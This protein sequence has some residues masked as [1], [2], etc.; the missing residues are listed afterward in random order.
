MRPAAA[1]L[2]WLTNA[3]FAA[4]LAC[5]ACAP[6]DQAEQAP[7]PP[8]SQTVP[9]DGAV[10]V[11]ADGAFRDAHGRFVLLHGVNLVDKRP[12]YLPS[13][14]EFGP[15]DASL[16]RDLGFNIVRLGF[17]WA[18]LEPER[19]IIDATYVARLVELVDLLGD[20]GI[21]VLLDSHQDVM[22]ERWGGE[23]FP[24][25]A[26]DDGGIPIAT[27]LGDWS[28]NVAQPSLWHAWDAFWAN[29]HGLVDRYV[30]AWQSVVA[31]VADRP[32]VLGYDLLNEPWPGSDFLSEGVDHQRMQPVYERLAVAIREID[33]D[34]VV[35]WEPDLATHLGRGSRIGPLGDTNVAESFHVYCPLTLYGVFRVDG[36]HSPEL[37]GA[38]SSHRLDLAA[39]DRARVGGGWLMTEFGATAL[40]ADAALH[41]E[42]ADQHLVGWTWW[43][44]KRLDDPTGEPDEALVPHDTGPLS[45]RSTALALERI[46]PRTVAGTP[47]SLHSDP[48]APTG[49]TSFELH[50]TADPAVSA[51]T[52]IWIPARLDPGDDG[53][54]VEGGS[55]TRSPDGRRLLVEPLDPVPTELSV[56]IEAT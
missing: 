48:M 10:T 34:G 13:P 26:V 22:N 24:D 47:V 46:Y 12:P 38:W 54:V 39:R 44:W 32:N 35:F 1:L 2:R 25:W 37:C 42:L 3:L 8:S 30:A 43:N 17:I 33:T 18:G 36:L 15:A 9:T 4:A 7:L 45:L 55:F 16:I 56:Q 6:V 23:G 14:D 21:L 52:E 53:I 28:F 50:F 27:G 19:G 20:H 29:E 11:D 41:A 31:A 49:A 51:P 40:V 5:A